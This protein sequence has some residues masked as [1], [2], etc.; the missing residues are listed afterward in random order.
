MDILS[1]N[2]RDLLHTKPILLIGDEEISKKEEIKSYFNKTFSLDEKVFDSIRDDHGFYV[3]S[4]PL[5][6]PLIFYFGHTA[7]FYV[8]KFTIAGL[9]NKRINPYFETMFAV[10][11]DEMSWDD[12]LPEHYDW[13]K[14][15]D[16]KKYREE[17]RLMV[18]QVID[19]TPL[20]LPIT[21]D[22]P[23]W[24]IV[25]AIEHERIHIE[26][27]SV[28]IRR[29]PIE[30]VK[31]T[32]YFP[33]CPIT[34]N[35][36]YNQGSNKPKIDNLPINQLLTVEKT[37]INVHKD[38][39]LYGWDNEY[40]EFKCNVPTFKA[41]K[42][43]VSNGEY[44]EFMEKGGYV[45]EE[46]W[47]EEGK[48]W[49]KSMKP[50]HP[51]FWIPEGFE[52]KYRTLTEII[53]M[54]WDWPVETNY[55]EAKAFCNWKATEMKKKIRL[56]T[57][58]EYFALRSLIKED[59]MDAGFEKKGN[60]GLY[61]WGSSCPVN[62]FESEGFC[63]I[64]G[65]VWQHSETA[66]NGFKGFKVHKYYDDFS[67]PTFDGKHNMIKGGSWIS[68]GNEAMLNSR[69]AFRRHFFQHAGF[70]YVEGEDFEE[71]QQ[72]F[73]YETDGIEAKQLE[74]NYG[75]EY[76]NV[77]NW[78]KKCGDICKMIA[79]E[80]EKPIL[81]VLDIGCTVGRT[82]FELAK[83]FP[84]VV[85]IDYSARFFHLAV[86]LKE[87][88]S[89]NYMRKVEGELLDY[90]RIELNEFDF[91]PYKD[92]VSFYQQP[93]V[94]NIDL[95]KFN[96][97]DLIFA[98]NTIETMPNP[99]DFLKKIHLPLSE[100]G[101]LV[102]ASTYDWKDDITSVKERL[103]GFRF[104]AETKTNY[105]GLKEILVEKFEEIKNPLEEDLVIR[106]SRM[107]YNHNCSQFT[108]WRKKIN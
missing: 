16:L 54:P 61:H 29:L 2:P 50:K 37:F 73:F 27:S 101:L 96:N 76:F 9:N 87:K 38:E 44:L 53:D 60:I 25:M 102:I 40:G 108:F 86:F 10:G 22:N 11:V 83:E 1:E 79:K 70:R 23:F 78:G 12:L 36:G 103:G 31:S 84:E 90:Q 91:Y 100:K 13:P 26:T 105:D 33:K 58:P 34:Y 89:L 107:K 7:A 14:V 104:N 17:V 48:R 57:E 106:E 75:Q 81:R 42:Y 20:K 72:E 88:G 15:A 28:I 6:H 82:S 67:T 95:M 99:K 94:S 74:F 52:F 80:S 69:Y 92:R 68:T 19:N 97:F 49:L 18:N 66:I 47:T 39:R 56:P 62:L 85:G 98:G 45:K 8:N 65:N 51:L 4:E 46:Y 71:S 55:L 21:W 5:R 64:L 41:S 3:R 35:Q 77:K 63:D 32:V 30:L 43:L 24:V 59:I 93:D